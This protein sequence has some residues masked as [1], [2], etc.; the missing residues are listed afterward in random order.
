[1]KFLRIPW[2]DLLVSVQD[3]EGVWR[4]GDLIVIEYYGGESIRHTFDKLADAMTAFDSIA[5]QLTK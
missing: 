5:Q 1:M 3:I 2:K 4:N